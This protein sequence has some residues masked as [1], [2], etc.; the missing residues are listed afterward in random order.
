MPQARARRGCLR[1]RACARA[2]AGDAGGPRRSASWQRATDM[3]STVERIAARRRDSGSAWRATSTRSQ[4][5]RRSPARRPRVACAGPSS[6]TSTGRARASPSKRGRRSA[7]IASASP[8]ASARSPRPARSCS[9]ARRRHADGDG[10]AARHARRGAARGSHRVRDGGCV[11]A[12][13]R[14]ARGRCRGRINLIS[15]PS[16][17]GDIEQTIVL[18]AHGPYRVHILVLG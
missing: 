4:L 16:R 10:A 17:T 5:R 13:P 2:A 7:T 15:G 6:A 8:D 3:A 18:G 14:G 9:P 12:D 11:C 1:R